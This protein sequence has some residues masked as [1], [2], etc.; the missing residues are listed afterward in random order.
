[1]SAKKLHYDKDTLLKD[2]SQV[3][4]VMIKA[5]MVIVF[6]VLLYL[7]VFI[8]YLGGW[9]HTPTEPFVEQFG[10]RISIDYEGKKLPLYEGL[11]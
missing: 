1:M 6:L 3:F 5:L 8:V 9:S 2:Y 10:D 4:T 11:N 7:F